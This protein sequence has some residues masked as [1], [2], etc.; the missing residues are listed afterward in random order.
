MANFIQFLTA[1]WP[2][3][4]QIL[5]ALAAVGAL[6]AKLTPTP[7]DDGVFAGILKFLNLLPNPANS[8]ASEE[9]KADEPTPLL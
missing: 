6:I 9:K 5:A 7:K 1:N 8:P 4:L 2:M 3:L